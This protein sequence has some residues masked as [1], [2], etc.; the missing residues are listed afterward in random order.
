MVVDVEW[1]DERELS[2]WLRLVAVLEMLPGG[3]TTAVR[4]GPAAAPTQMPW[5]GFESGSERCGPGESGFT[6]G[7]SS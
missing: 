5:P 6:S 4:S 7:R 3:L 1:L 2:A